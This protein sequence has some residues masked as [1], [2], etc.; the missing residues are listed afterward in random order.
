MFGF[1]CFKSACF[2]PNSRCGAPGPG[3]S[4]LA[5]VLG[6][7]DHRHRFLWNQ[8]VVYAED[9]RMSGGMDQGINDLELVVKAE[10]PVPQRRSED[11]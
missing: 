2:R 4:L 10:A 5:L 1:Y 3:N 9:G 11:R 6:G 7:V 8:R